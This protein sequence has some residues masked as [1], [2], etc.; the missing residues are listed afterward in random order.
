MD[1]IMYSILP[2]E[3]FFSGYGLL[4]ICCDPQSNLDPSHRTEVDNLPELPDC[5]Y[6][7]RTQNGRY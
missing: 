6:A 1:A 2:S 5:G 4:T 7:D 3:E